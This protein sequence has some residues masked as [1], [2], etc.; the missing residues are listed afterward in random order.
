MDQPSGRS[1]KRAGRCDL[2]VP[3]QVETKGASYFAVTENICTGGLFIATSN[4]GRAGEQVMLRLGL[5]GTGRVVSV[6]AEIRWVRPSADATLRHGARGMGVQ[7]VN[8][9][10]DAAATVQEYL[11]HGSST[12]TTAVR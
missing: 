4:P 9:S 6:D 11:R 3:I 7:F 2:Q 1:V 12:I 8:I 10:L 5:P